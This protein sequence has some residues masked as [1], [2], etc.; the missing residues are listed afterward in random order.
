MIIFSNSSYFSTSSCNFYN[1]ILPKSNVIE[2]ILEIYYKK[3][4]QRMKDGSIFNPGFDAGDLIFDPRDS[5]Y[6]IWGGALDKPKFMPS[7]GSIVAH[8]HALDIETFKEH[9]YPDGWTKNM[10]LI[11]S[12]NSL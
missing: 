4:E 7:T 3:E 5:K 10:I 6:K 2:N 12:F 1:E 9:F 11:T 8:Y